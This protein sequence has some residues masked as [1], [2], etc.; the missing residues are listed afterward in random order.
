MNLRGYDEW[1]QTEPDHRDGTGPRLSP[2]RRHEANCRILV[3]EIQDGCRP[4]ARWWAIQAVRSARA[5]GLYP[6]TAQLEAELLPRGSEAR[7]ELEC[8]R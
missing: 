3:Q 7:L 2:E 1:K 6:S 8:S 5:L 4:I